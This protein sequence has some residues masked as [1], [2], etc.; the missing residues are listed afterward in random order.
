MFICSIY[1]YNTLY[2]TKCV[3]I[4]VVLIGLGPFGWVLLSGYRRGHTEQDHDGQ[5]EDRA[6]EERE[7]VFVPACHHLVP[8]LHSQ[9]LLYCIEY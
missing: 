8:V 9:A 2:T 6:A 4:T 5:L 3:N 1:S 7:H